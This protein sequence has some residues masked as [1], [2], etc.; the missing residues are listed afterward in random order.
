M[1]ENI[2]DALECALTKAGEA[3]AKS[4]LFSPASKSFDKYKNFE[5]RGRVLDAIAQKLSR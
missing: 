2:T 1:R 3:G 4:V 5:E